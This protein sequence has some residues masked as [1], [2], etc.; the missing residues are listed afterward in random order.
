MKSDLNI[1]KKLASNTALLL[2]S[3]LMS[4]QLIAQSPRE[5]KQKNPEER[6]KR[7]MTKMMES[8]DGMTDVQ[9][10]D[11]QVL[12]AKYKPEMDAL[13]KES[14]TKAQNVRKEMKPKMD[15]LRT[16]LD[17]DMSKVLNQEQMAQYKSFQVEVKKKRM[18]RKGQRRK[19]ASSK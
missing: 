7:H 1:M 2:T 14:K 18:E 13:R 10:T 19:A 4:T 16:M 8:I 3:V 12:F 11:I 5:G 6:A 9:K 15:E 17:A